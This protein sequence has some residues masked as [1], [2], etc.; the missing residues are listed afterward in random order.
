[1]RSPA[2]ETLIVIAHNANMAFA[3]T[4]R[5]VALRFHFLPF[6]IVSDMPMLPPCDVQVKPSYVIVHD[7][8]MAFVRELEMYKAEH[9]ERPLKVYFL[10]Y[11]QSTE[12]RKF[13]SSI[14]RE[15]AAFET[16]IRQKAIMT[17]PVDQV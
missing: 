9:P 6:V 15:N 4:L 14:K 5:K 10:L 17:V 8:D 7:P 13:E 11:E 1:M 12:E 3:R 2:A 16:L